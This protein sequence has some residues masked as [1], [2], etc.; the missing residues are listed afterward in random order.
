MTRTRQCTP[1]VL[2]QYYAINGHAC[3]GARVANRCPAASVR[4]VAHNLR[5]PPRVG[6]C[7]PP[8]DLWVMYRKEMI[9]HGWS[10]YLRR[11]Q[12]ATRR[13]HLRE[14][15][16]ASLN[17][18]FEKLTRYGVC[19]TLVVKKTTAWFSSTSYIEAPPQFLVRR[20]VS[21]QPSSAASEEL[22][23]EFCV[24]LMSLWRCVTEVT[25]QD[26]APES[27]E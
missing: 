5:W 10:V 17:T 11:V 18:F 20:R 16:V 4:L 24:S 19:G 13:E 14:C 2:A 25:A 15:V 3:W 9:V 1:K 7:D 21:R 26:R 8:V 22:Y 6:V 12:N 23:S 27:V